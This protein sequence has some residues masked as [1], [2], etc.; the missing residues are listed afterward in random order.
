MKAFILA[1][2][3][4]ERMRPLTD[5][6]PKPLLEAGG[7]P[8]IVHMTELVINVSH[9][10]DQIEAFLGDGSRW[11]VNIEYSHEPVALE[12]A[13]GI[14]NALRLLG[15]EPFILVN[16]DI[17]TDFD[18]S[19]LTNKSLAESLGHLVMVNN[20]FHHAE[21]DFLLDEGKLGADKG[22]RLTY[23]GIGLYSPMLFAKL[24]PGKRPLGPVLRQAISDSQ[25]TGEK[26]TGEW[27]DVGTPQRLHQLDEL[28]KK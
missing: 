3:R 1:A 17:W 4:G 26:Y 19:V 11:G 22:E 9:L 6:T 13:G 16:G 15:D 23:S 8:L 20:P 14:V 21:G 5:S 18:F 12:T 2:G 27:V 25:L 10:G 24:A 7:E 28:L